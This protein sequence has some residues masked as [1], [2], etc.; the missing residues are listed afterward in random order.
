MKTVSAVRSTNHKKGSAASAILDRDTTDE[1]VNI[2]KSL[3]DPSRLLILLTLAR[4]GKMHVSA[5]CGQLDQSQPAVSHHLTQL[6]NAKLVRFD[7]EGKYNFYQLDSK[8]LEKM[9]DLFFPGAGS[10][11]QRVAYGDLEL[12]FK[13]K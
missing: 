13:K 12:T 3:A 5:I 2:F 11:Q 7:R 8:M 9:I 10:A 6:R 1:L 4:E